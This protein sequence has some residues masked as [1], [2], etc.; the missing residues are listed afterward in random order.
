[1]ANSRLEKIGTIFSR[2]HG[3]I[4]SG[5]LKFE[6]RPIWYD[7]YEKFPPFNEPKFD[8]KV[9]ATKIREIFYAEDKDRV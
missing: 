3:L 4:K 5:A 1:M 6:E 8:Q 9:E 7:V 2:V